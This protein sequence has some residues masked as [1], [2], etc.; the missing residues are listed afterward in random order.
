MNEDENWIEA[1]AG[2][3]T[4]VETEQAEPEQP[5]ATRERG[6]DGKF[7]KA[8]ADRN[9]Q[10]AEK[11]AKEAAQAEI[12]EPPS[13]DNESGTVPIHVLKA[14]REENR[15]L[16]AQLGQRQPQQPTQPATGYNPPSVNFETDPAGLAREVLSTKL[17]MSRF[18][19]EQ[20]ASPDEINEAWNE[21]DQ[22]CK[23]DPEV[24]AMSYRLRG[25]PHPFG[26]IVKWH[27]QR[28]DMRALQEAG[29]Y[30]ALVERLKAELSQQAP[31]PAQPRKAVPPS[32][33]GTGR[34]RTSSQTNDDDGEF[35]GLFKN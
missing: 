20:Q 23:E 24:S 12:D 35:Y 28:Q 31:S 2:E 17:Q 33:A 29:G 3:E 19:M 15:R 5:V 25:H 9:S 11:G 18:M 10:R 22:A 21:F 6:P 14:I 7:I 34:P 16:K 30:Q 1:F 8:E 26:E 13:D 32:L 27:R 4:V